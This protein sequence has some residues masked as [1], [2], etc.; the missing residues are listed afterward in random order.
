MNHSKV[1]KVILF[2]IFS[3]ETNPKTQLNVMISYKFLISQWTP[4]RLQNSFGYVIAA[5]SIAWAL[6]LPWLEYCLVLLQV[7]FLVISLAD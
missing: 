1:L 5:G 6:L 3:I 2:K 7:A 4:V